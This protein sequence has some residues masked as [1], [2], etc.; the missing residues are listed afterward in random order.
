MIAQ[1]QADT[2]G[3]MTGSGPKD[4]ILDEIRAGVGNPITDADNL[5][6]INEVCNDPYLQQ[7]L[8]QLSNLPPIG[9][10]NYVKALGYD[11]ESHI[12]LIWTMCQQKYI[13]DNEGKWSNDLVGGGMQP[14]DLLSVLRDA[15]NWLM[16][17]GTTTYQ[18]SKEIGR[19]LDSYFASDKDVM[20]LVNKIKQL[21]LRVEALERTVEKVS[22]EE[23][24]E[25]KLDM[26]K[27]YN[28]TSVKCGINSTTYWNAKKEGFDNY[29]TIAYKDCTED[30][31]CVKWSDCVDGTQTRK[32]VDKNDC[33][34]FSSK[35]A[36]I[37]TC[38]VSSQQTSQQTALLQSIASTPS[39]SVTKVESFVTMSQLI[40]EN[41]MSILVMALI[42]IPAT[43]IIVGIKKDLSAKRR[44]R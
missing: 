33:G 2:Y 25:S 17:G 32:C 6:K 27:V 3:T 30:W 5:D 21:E 13:K 40:T 16:G 4:M 12:N 19:T 8:G 35:P 28:L 44:R 23:Y 15:V 39:K 10:V 43:L 38:Q 34:T 31:I 9:F 26:M 1:T 36:E 42:S 7:W 37:Q 29:D 20:T 18:Q 41:Y 11:D 14:G 22:S 24:C